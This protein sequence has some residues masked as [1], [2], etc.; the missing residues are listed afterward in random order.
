VGFVTLPGS[1][2]PGCI[3]QHLLDI[4]RVGF[5]PLSADGKNIPQI[6]VVAEAHV[7]LHLVKPHAHNGHQGVFLTVN[8]VVFQSFIGRIKIDGNGM[9]AKGF[10]LLHDDPAFH[11][12]DTFV[13][14]IFRFA[15]GEVGGKVLKPVF[16][17]GHT[18][19]IDG[20][21]FFQQHPP[22]FAV[23][24]GVDI[25]RSGKIKGQISIL[26]G[27]NGH[28]HFS[29]RGQD[30]IQLAAPCHFDHLVV[31]AQLLSRIDGNL[32]LIVGSLT[33][34]LGVTQSCLMQGGVFGRVMPETQI[35]N[36]G[37]VGTLRQC[38]HALIG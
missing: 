27:W 24:H 28:A 2:L 4:Q 38:L 16:P 14:K 30:N 7:R 25:L 11:D 6:G 29:R 17:E 26:H 18:D 36:S 20:L 31:I 23:Q 37:A 1:H 8:H 15:D 33:N 13:F 10:K 12:T 22:R 9:G 32:H 34:K 5:K 35:Q 3:D 19:Q 21:E